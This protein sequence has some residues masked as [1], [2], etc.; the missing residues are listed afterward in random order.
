M[1]NEPKYGRRMFGPR[2]ISA[3]IWSNSTQEPWTDTEAVLGTIDPLKNFYAGAKRIVSYHQSIPF[4]IIMKW[5]LITL[6]PWA[7]ES[8]MFLV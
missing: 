1:N 7:V 5:A 3:R 2:S 4:M 8:E 6:K